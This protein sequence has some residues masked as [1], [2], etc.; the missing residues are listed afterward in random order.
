MQTLR[1]NFHCTY[2]SSCEDDCLADISH[3][4][5]IISKQLFIIK[6]IFGGWVTL[7]FNKLGKLQ[8]LNQT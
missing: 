1:I 7:S 2:R 5:D 6:S 4:L 8:V 3:G